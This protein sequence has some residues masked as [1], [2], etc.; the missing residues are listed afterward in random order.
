MSRIARVVIPGCPHHIIQRGNRKQIV[1]F[2]NEDKKLYIQILRKQAKQSG[3][4]FWAYC[5]MDNHVH[6]IAVPKYEESLARGIG[7]AHRRYSSLINIRNN[8]TGYLWQGRFLSYPL[9]GKYLI[10]A[11]R[12]VERNPVRACLVKN[13]EDYSW[14]SAKSHVFR[15][16]DSLLTD[17]YLLHE[18]PDWAS[19]LKEAENEQDQIL[20][21]KHGR[22]GR[23]LGDDRFIQLLEE[24]TGRFFGKKKPG[25]KKVN[26]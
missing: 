15:T 6:L 4:S 22:T 21:R 23:P 10:A 8:W 5:L 13:A 7:E 3:I 1:F 2:N 12:Y 24:K 18:F 16:E 9:D 14:S 17:N 26:G 11:V 20:I 25:R 19:F